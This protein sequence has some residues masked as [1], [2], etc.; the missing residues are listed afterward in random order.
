MTENL[1]YFLSTG[2]LLGLSAGFA[3][4]PLSTLVLTQTLQYGKAEGLKVAVSPI[5]TDVPIILLCLLV[6]SKLSNF[7]IALAVI[8]FAG[9]TFVAYLGIDSIRTKGLDNN[10]SGQVK[11]QALKKGIITNIL[12]PHPYLFWMTIGTPLIFKALNVSIIATIL[13][14][15]SF[16]I[17]IVGSKVLIALLV[18]RTKGLLNQKTYLVIMRGLGIALLIFSVM[19]VYEGIGYL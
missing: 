7:D 19:I 8:S 11:P 18:A 10:I 6:L 3:P 9:A 12:S 14:L 17:C 2:C 4:G 13:F 16:Y 1:I 5:I 15:G